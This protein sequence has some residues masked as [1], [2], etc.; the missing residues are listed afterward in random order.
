M[1]TISYVDP[2]PYLDQHGD[3]QGQDRMAR[4]FLRTLGR[5]HPGAVVGL[6]GAPGSGKN[7]FLRHCAWLLQTQ[8]PQL[9]EGGPALGAWAWYNPW[10]YTKHGNILSGLVATVAQSSSAPNAMDRARDIIQQINRMHFGESMPEHAGTGINRGDVNPVLRVRESFKQLLDQLV[11]EKPGRVVVLIEDVDSLRPS[12]RL[13]LLEGLRILATDQHPITFVLS[14][15]H[16]S[17]LE[18]VRVREGRDLGPAAARHCLDELLDLA[19]TV[20]STDVRQLPGLIQGMLQGHEPLLTRAFGP[21]AI[22]A[23]S[24]AVA[25]RS[26]GQVRVL[27]RLT[28]RV[29]LLAQY[30]IDTRNQRELSEAQ[31]AWILVSERWPGFRQFMLRGGRDRWGHLRQALRGLGPDG[32]PADTPPEVGEW[33]EKD[34]IFADYLRIYAD[35]FEREADAVYWLETLQLACGL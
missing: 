17:A 20:P 11:T 23:L 30:A 15:G 6:H 3:P 1:P 26:L 18:A 8:R 4:A 16:Q 10:L 14:V 12:A 7:A 33:L 29:L 34:L 21:D 22:G 24:A 2:R 19:V 35:E 32:L 5:L 9:N 13:M 25:H 31:W 27:E 28:G